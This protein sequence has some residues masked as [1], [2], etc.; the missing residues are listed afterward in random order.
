MS[1]TIVEPLVQHHVALPATIQLGDVMLSNFPQFVVP[2]KRRD[3][4]RPQA[5]TGIV[6]DLQR[7][8]RICHRRFIGVSLRIVPDSNQYVSLKVVV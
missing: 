1:S 3:A 5:G 4:R 7:Q 2:M 6:V 8:I